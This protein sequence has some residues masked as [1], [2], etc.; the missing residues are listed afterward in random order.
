[1]SPEIMIVGLKEIGASIGLALAKAGAGGSR[2]GYDADSGVARAARKA[3]AVERLALNL[4]RSCRSADLVILAVPSCEVRPYLEAIGA[5]LKPGALVLDTSSL[6]SA[7]IGWASEHLPEGCYYVGAVPVVNPTALHIG[8]PGLGEPRADLFR[9]GLMAMVIPVK[10][11]E[12][13]VEL[14]LSVARTLGAAPFFIEPS[15]VDAV[16]ATVEGLPALL[17]IALVR[18]AVQTPG[19]RE[20]RRIAGRQFAS[21]AIVGA[22]QSPQDL[23]ASLDLNRSNVLARVDAA[24]EELRALRA[25]IAQEEAEGLRA[26]LAEAVEAHD[27]WLA[28]RAQGEWGREELGKVELPEG[29]MLD[30]LLGI[31]GNLRPK[32]RG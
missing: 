1:M 26:S 29:G 20:A 10:T 24:I 18:V 15:E 13:V 9:G 14:A 19:W 31:G 28:A 32:D 3:G 17:A 21:L 30:R 4:G 2:T 11:P 25:L 27:A 22:L 5:G 8:A 16:M 12:A 7:A 6:K 23:Q